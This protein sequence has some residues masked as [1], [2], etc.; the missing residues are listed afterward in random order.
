MTETNARKLVNLYVEG[1]KTNDMDRILEPLASDCSV[2]ESHGSSYKNP[3]LIRKWIKQWNDAGN[4]VTKWDIDAFFFT[5][6][7]TF[8]E[9]SFECVTNKKRHRLDGASIV[10]FR[11]D[12]IHHIHEYR[13]T[14]PSY[15]WKPSE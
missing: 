11:G 15:D 10:L 4:K 6:D 9:W 14:K 8:F 3:K 7:S 13:M 1:W 2:T 12:K 5:G